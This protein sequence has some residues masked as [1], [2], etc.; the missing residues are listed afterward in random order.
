M[1][2]R[3][4]L[5]HLLV[6]LG[7]AAWLW[8]RCSCLKRNNSLID[9]LLVLLLFKVLSYKWLACLQIL[10]GCRLLQCAIPLDKWLLVVVRLRWFVVNNFILLIRLLVLNS[11][12]LSYNRLFGLLGSWLRKIIEK[13][14]IVF[15][16][17][18]DILL[19]FYWGK[20]SEINL[21]LN[22]G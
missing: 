21:R 16:F 2:Q 22:F 10:N 3:Q 13:S 12:H 14:K 1:R 17:A 18:C 4:R 9:F 8:S 11:S 6:C 7:C 19:L 15:V 20:W 5:S